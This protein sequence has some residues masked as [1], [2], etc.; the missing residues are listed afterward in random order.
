MDEQITKLLKQL[1]AGG[2]TLRMRAVSGSVNPAH[3]E[4]KPEK[5]GRHA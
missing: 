4:T 1:S 3:P 5:G 2:S